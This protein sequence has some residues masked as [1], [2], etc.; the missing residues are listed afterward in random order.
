[1]AYYLDF[2][3][4]TG[5][6]AGTWTWTNGSASVTEAA[7]DGDAT[8]MAVG[9]YVRMS[10][11][12]QWYK[13]ASV[14]NDD[15]F[16][17]T[18]V[19]QQATHTDDANVSMWSDI[20]EANYGT[21]T[22]LAAAHIN[23][24][25]TDTAR[26]A[27]HI[28]YVRANQTHVVAGIDIPFDESGSI[29]SYI[30]IIGCDSVTNDPWGDAS[31]VKPIFNFSN[32][33]F[34]FILNGDKFWWI[35]K[36]DFRNSA[37]TAGLFYVQTSAGIQFV[38]CNFGENT[39]AV[40]ALGISGAIITL[41]GCAFSN[42][43]AH[44]VYQVGGNITLID[45]TLDAGASGSTYGLYN[46]NGVTR[47]IGGSIAV[48]NSF[49]TDDIQVLGS[50]ICY[51]RNVDLRASPDITVA[52]AYADGIFCEDYDAT[53]ES[54]M[55]YFYEGTIT[56]ATASPR[57]GGA[58]SYAVML[59]NA[60]CGLLSP[61]ILGN[62]MRG[63]AAI[64]A[65]KDVEINVAIYACVKTAWDSALGATETYARFSYLSNAATAARTEVQSTETISNV[66][67]TWT[68]LTSGNITPLQTGWVYVWAYLAEF[69]DATE[70]VWVDIK[71]VVTTV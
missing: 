16:T 24:Y 14:V 48:T 2:N 50:G 31:D 62:K 42:S 57:A 34:E 68:A 47:M 20:S 70:E 46:N 23:W 11:G 22:L 60:N 9:D 37:D 27:G 29:D 65:T 8:K 53:F 6:L 18:P 28:L 3:R 25:T 44:S 56:R 38:D 1:M 66:A 35:E 4:H 19:F 43:I 7:S 54:Q 58:D 45:C 5:H 69:E 15:S 64:W 67:E 32:T 13:V 71:P 40:P 61:L 39:T 59:S 36:L 17:I 55:T 12:T 49:S 26:S 41:D 21:T 63:F 33:L 51:L 52:V 30:S 10:D